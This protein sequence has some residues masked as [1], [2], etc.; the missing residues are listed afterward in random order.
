MLALAGV[1]LVVR[2]TLSKFVTDDVLRS[3]R[4]NT[5]PVRSY[6]SIRFPVLCVDYFDVT[7]NGVEESG[8]MSVKWKLE[9]KGTRRKWW[10]V[11]RDRV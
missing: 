3:P 5:G 9:G 11:T 7:R 4:D 2:R 8:R 1:V 10:V 6:S